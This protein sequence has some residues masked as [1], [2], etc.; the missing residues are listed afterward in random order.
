MEVRLIF[1]SLSLPSNNVLLFLLV[2]KISLPGIPG[3]PGLPDVNSIASALGSPEAKNLLGVLDV[4]SLSS[5]LTNGTVESA[6]NN[7]QSI[8][9]NAAKEAKASTDN[10]LSNLQTYGKSISQE[11]DN[12]SKSAQAQINTTMQRLSSDVKDCVNKNGNPGSA[13][14]EAARQSAQR[15]VQNKINEASSIVNGTLR[16]IEAAQ[17]GV[18]YLR[19]NLSNCQLNVS[20]SLTSLP[21][22]SASK[23]A[24]I[25]SVCI[26]FVIIKEFCIYIRTLN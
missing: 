17:L 8:S 5:P 18:N 21:T 6:L 20:A 10:A 2:P 4:S 16:D 19:G 1:R 7:L 15:C 13:G 26:F 25:A 23:P 24:C 9:D 3:L 14:V 11:I 22:F 12:V